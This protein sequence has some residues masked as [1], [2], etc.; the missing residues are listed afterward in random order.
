MRLIDAE[1]L[2]DRFKPEKK[3]K[4]FRTDLSGIKI[5]LEEAPTVE[6]IPVSKINE[7][8]G[9]IAHI[10]YKGGVMYK[11]KYII[12]VEDVVNVL[13]DIQEACDDSGRD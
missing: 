7:A 6:A 2:I 13:N 9:R 8:I 5:L 11:G 3:Y 4:C 12:S 10:S 1:A